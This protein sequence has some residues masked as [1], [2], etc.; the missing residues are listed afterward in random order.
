[1][2]V[3]EAIHFRQQLVEGGVALVVA[4]VAA[5]GAPHRVDLVHED[6]AGLQASGLHTPPPPP[7]GAPEP[8]P[9]PA[10]AAGGPVLL[11]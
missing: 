1:M 8:H 11:E 6:D 4:L 5:P 3:A 7:L 2:L 9:R 10:P